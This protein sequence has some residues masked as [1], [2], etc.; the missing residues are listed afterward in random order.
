MKEIF[1]G[2]SPLR[3]KTG[4]D[5]ECHPIIGYPIP[6]LTLPLKGREENQTHLRKREPQT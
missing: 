2:S 3:G 5:G 4:G 6:T 1:S